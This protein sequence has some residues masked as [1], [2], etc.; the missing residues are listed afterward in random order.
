MRN[1]SK[2]CLHKTLCG[3]VVKQSGSL[4]KIEDLAAHTKGSLELMS[5]SF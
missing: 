1:C 4:G 2:V 3:L 5:P